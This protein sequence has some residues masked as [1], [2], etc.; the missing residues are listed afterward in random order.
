MSL[1]LKRLPKFDSRRPRT[2]VLMPTVLWLPDD[3]E[4]PVRLRNISSAG[5]MGESPGDLQSGMSLGVEIPAYG[6]VRATIRWSEDGKLGA[7]FDTPLELD[8]ID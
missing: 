2:A 7:Y 3:R 1:S 6:I 5:F 4:M 8:W